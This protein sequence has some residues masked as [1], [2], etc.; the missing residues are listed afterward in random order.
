MRCGLC[1][2]GGPVGHLA[3]GEAPAAVH[4]VHRHVHCA[5]PALTRWS[6]FWADLPSWERVSPG[7]GLAL[8][9]SRSSSL[10]SSVHCC[11]IR[12]MRFV[13][14][15]RAE[16]LLSLCSQKVLHSKFSRS[17]NRSRS[18]GDV[19]QVL[20][21][22]MSANGGWNGEWAQIVHRDGQY[23]KGVERQWGPVA[24]H[25]WRRTCVDGPAYNEPNGWV[26]FPKS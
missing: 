3:D 5:P 12:L 17:A 24:A 8:G 16:A 6:H 22:F 26:T 14:P 4:V 9:A 18:F 7:S 13:L 19:Q 23:L 11:R 25:V 20:P 2:E 10:C 1:R 15:T 21:V